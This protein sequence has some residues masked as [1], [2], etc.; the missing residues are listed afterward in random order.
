MVH[1][2]LDRQVRDIL[3]AVV[4][5]PPQAALEQSRRQ[6]RGWFE[7]TAPSIFWDSFDSPI[8]PLYI[9]AT[10]LGLAHVAFGESVETFLSRLDPLARIVHDPRAAAPYLAP[11][12]AY[13]ERGPAPF[14]VPIDLSEV[15]PFRRTA[16]Q[17]IRRIPAGEVWTYKQVAEALGKPKASRAVGQAMASNPVPIVIPCHRVVGSDGSL[18]GYGGGGG[19]PTKR[20]LLHFEGAL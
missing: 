4:G 8:G 16:L 3:H 14:D 12:R 13:F 2:D 10:D 6:V 20:W 9:A 15:P 7:K 1:D 18:T 19:I 5:D 17:F 11:L